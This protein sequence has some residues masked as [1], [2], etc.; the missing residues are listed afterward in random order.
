M[1]INSFN[2]QICKHVL[3]RKM[4]GHTAKGWVDW[5][6]REIRIKNRETFKVN[7]TQNENVQQQISICN[8]E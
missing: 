7:F 5:L 3:S 4:D 6:G 1:F 2:M 8:R